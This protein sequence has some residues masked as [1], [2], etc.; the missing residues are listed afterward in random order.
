MSE[1]DVPFQV[2]PYEKLEYT[3]NPFM[4]IVDRLKPETGPNIYLCFFSSKTKG[5][6][7]YYP[8]ES[9]IKAL[10]SDKTKLKNSTDERKI[11]TI[12]GTTIYYFLKLLGINDFLSS[13]EISKDTNDGNSAKSK[14]GMIY[15]AILKS[16]SRNNCCIIYASDI[17]SADT[18]L[19]EAVKNGTI[20]LTSDYI[21]KTDD[22]IAQKYR[23]HIDNTINAKKKAEAEQKAK[24][25]AEENIKKGKERSKL[26]QDAITSIPD[27]VDLR[28][29][30]FTLHDI[31]KFSKPVSDWDPTNLPIKID[32][33]YSKK[34]IPSNDAKDTI[35]R[36]FSWVKKVNESKS[37]HVI[38]VKITNRPSPI[39]L[40]R[41]PK[42]T[43]L[44]QKDI[45]YDQNPDINASSYEVTI[46]KLK[47]NGRHSNDELEF[48][49]RMI[50]P[51]ID[52]PENNGEKYFVLNAEE[53]EIA[54]DAEV[55]VAGADDDAR[56]IKVLRYFLKKYGICYVES[57]VDKKYTF[58]FTHDDYI[59]IEINPTNKWNPTYL[60]FGNTPIGLFNAIPFVLHCLKS[61]KLL[62]EQIDNGPSTPT[63]EVLVL[64]QL[65]K[66]K[67]S[68]ATSVYFVVEKNTKH[69]KDYMP[70]RGFVLDYFGDI[71]GFTGPVVMHNKEWSLGCV[72][73][74]L[75]EPECTTYNELTLLTTGKTAYDSYDIDGYKEY[76]STGIFPESFSLVTRGSDDY[77]KFVGLEPYG[78][79]FDKSW[80]QCKNHDQCFDRVISKPDIGL[81]NEQ[82][83]VFYIFN[84]AN[85]ASAV[86]AFNARLE[87]EMK[88]VISVED[89]NNVVNKANLDSN[90]FLKTFKS[91][92]KS[93][94]SVYATDSITPFV[95]SIITDG[96]TKINVLIPENIQL[97]YV[98][99]VYVSNLRPDGFMDRRAQGKDQSQSVQQVQQVQQVPQQ[100]TPPRVR[101]GNERRFGIGAFR[102]NKGGGKSNKKRTKKSRRNKVRSNK[103]NARSNKRATRSNKRKYN[104]TRKK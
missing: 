83:P 97:E 91:Y 52:N 79:V 19:K 42:Y 11:T 3:E 14:Y 25:D 33:S 9:V 48:K 46:E 98:E 101:P 18:L 70:G 73:S 90:P 68:S 63:P 72:Q 58:K 55:V 32:D 64:S 102:F 100:T 29:Q 35:P 5:F 23:Q 89:G 1:S 57:P 16:Y 81:E 49:K 20:T 43:I 88:K 13:A 94:N 103:H 67:I 24:N 40:D 28:W 47:L 37:I 30:V 71:D 12:N 45:Y 65:T 53:D 75:D 76:L 10:T 2:I 51:F 17:D 96:T 15:D 66:D 31:P 99:P 95:K 69:R 36:D 80:I 34:G 41:F 87:E 39:D 8:R 38:S 54:A 84:A 62:M 26:I 4:T 104:N 56:E 50:L 60:T 44:G 21:T 77:S 22:N 86:N 6:I 7:Y 93:S 85:K 78:N 92:N 61:D 59:N 27:T 74:I 82:H